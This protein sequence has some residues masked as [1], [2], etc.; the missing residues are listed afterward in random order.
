LEKIDQSALAPRTLLVKVFGLL[1]NREAS[2]VLQSDAA[3]PD[4]S[5]RLVK[6]PSGVAFK[7]KDRLRDSW[8]DWSQFISAFFQFLIYVIG[9]SY[10]D[11]RAADV[12]AQSDE[13]KVR[14]GK[15]QV[16][17]E[18]TRAL[19]A[20]LRQEELRNKLVQV[21]RILNLARENRLW[22]EVALGILQ[23][24]ARQDG[25]AKRLLAVILKKAG[26]KLVK[27]PDELDVEDLLEAI[28][29]AKSRLA[30]LS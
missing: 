17:M 23:Q 13:L 30:I 28:E 27:S 24:D 19:T 3:I 2:F 20:K 14:I 22:R 29:E 12:S 1:P 8:F 21:R 7:S 9:I 5:V 4:E 18:E 25:A 16:E 15:A 6:G 26:I 10:F 11:K